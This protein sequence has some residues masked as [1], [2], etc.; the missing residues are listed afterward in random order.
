MRAQSEQRAAAARRAD[1]L[2][3]AASSGVLD[4]AAQEVAREVARTNPGLLRS[5]VTMMGE[6]D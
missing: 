5:F 2:S 3:D 4:R 1:A 6:A